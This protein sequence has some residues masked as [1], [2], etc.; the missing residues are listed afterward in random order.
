MPA[1]LAHASQPKLR[2]AS[3]NSGL[4]ALASDLPA[5]ARALASQAGLKPAS[6]KPAGPGRAGLGWPAQAWARARAQASQPGLR[7]SPKPAVR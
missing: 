1:S 6:P 7:L 4:P 2:P 3:P 5:R